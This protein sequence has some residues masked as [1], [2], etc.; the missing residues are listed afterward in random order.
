MDVN[1]KDLAAGGIFVAFAAAYGTMSLTTMPVGTPTQMGPGFFPTMLAGCLALIGLGVIV[2]AFFVA[3]THPFG[4]K[5][6]RALIM[7]SLATIVFGAF[8]EALGMLPGT[9][10]TTFIACLASPK[11]KL[12][13]ALLTAACIAALCSLIFTVALGVPLP[14]LGTLFRP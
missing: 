12:W 8:V 5:P 3:S 2:R 6:W 11:I 14:I 13:Q 10:A 1:R 9:F 4:A 7:L